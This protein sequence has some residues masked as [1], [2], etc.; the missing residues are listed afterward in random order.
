MGARQCLYLVGGLG[1][2]VVSQ[3]RCGH[4]VSLL[5]GRQ[6]LVENKYSLQMLF[7]PSVFFLYLDNYFSSI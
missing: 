4:F 7:Y 3:A 6:F 1:Q 5:G 2:C